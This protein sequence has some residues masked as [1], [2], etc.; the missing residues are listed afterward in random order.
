MYNGEWKDGKHHGKGKMTYAN[1][2][3]Y[4]GEWEDGKMTYAD[5]VVYNGEWKDGK[6]HVGK[7]TYA[8]GDVYDG[9][10]KMIA[11]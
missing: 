6:K 8:N 1:G 5:G 3:V 2:D 7:M 11:R 10:W 4:D 9:E